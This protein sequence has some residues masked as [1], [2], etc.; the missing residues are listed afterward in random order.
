MLRPM[1][2][3]PEPYPIKAKRTKLSPLNASD[4]ASLIE[5]GLSK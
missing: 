3:G 4:L 2:L 5:L 1:A